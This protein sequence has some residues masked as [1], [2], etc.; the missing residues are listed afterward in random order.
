MKVDQETMREFEEW[1]KL[2][3]YSIH[4][5]RTYKKALNWELKQL[6]RS[7]SNRRSYLTAIHTFIRFLRERY[8]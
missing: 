3:G 1:L 5:I 4:T 2:Q 8:Y 7:E 6:K